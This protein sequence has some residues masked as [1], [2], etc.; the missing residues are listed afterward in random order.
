M[1]DMTRAGEA[2][3]KTD[4]LGRVRTTRERREQLLDEFEPG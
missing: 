1:T 2:V 3:I 4:T